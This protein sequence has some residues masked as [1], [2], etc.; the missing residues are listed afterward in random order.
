MYSPQF[1]PYSQNTLFPG[2]SLHTSY[3]LAFH[4]CLLHFHSSLVT[5]L[6]CQVC[7]SLFQNFLVYSFGLFLLLCPLS[8]LCIVISGMLKCRSPAWPHITFSIFH[9]ELRI[10]RDKCFSFWQ[11]D[12]SWRGLRISNAAWTEEKHF[13]IKRIFSKE[14]VKNTYFYDRCSL[15][16]WSLFFKSWWLLWPGTHLLHPIQTVVEPALWAINIWS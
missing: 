7:T 2:H 9:S 6:V 12:G 5:Y 13:E 15:T 4:F 16:Y 1:C 11:P 14:H 3:F 10:F 8:P